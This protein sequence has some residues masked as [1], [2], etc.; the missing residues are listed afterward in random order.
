MSN[1]IQ[2]KYAEIT[3]NLS[4]SNLSKFF[5]SEDA[6]ARFIT[7]LQVMM[8]NNPSII[9]NCTTQSIIKAAMKC[10]EWGI[11]LNQDEAYI[12]AYKGNDA[13]LQLGYK[14]LI[15]M[16]SR[17]N[18]KAK[19]NLVYKGE[20]IEIEEGTNPRITHKRDLDYQANHDIRGCYSIA[21]EEGSYESNEFLYMS[22]SDLEKTRESSKSPN[23]PAWQ[24][25]KGEMFK[26]VV[27]K[28]HLK[29]L[30]A[31][32]P[33]TREV[34]VLKNAIEMDNKE[35]EFTDVNKSTDTK[36]TEKVT[37]TTNKIKNLIDN[38]LPVIELEPDGGLMPELPRTPTQIS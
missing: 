6:L 19:A 32:L 22:F 7:S 37:E 24:N 28:R 9:Q 30:I 4:K 15:K 38:D 20:E 25:F 14:G 11:N 35:Y 12:I 2:T 31:R 36:P 34:Q 16:A 5:T 26:K 8:I 18:I 17:A 27:L 29:T 23:S 21:T 3:Q 10:G 13:Q 1:T 33:D